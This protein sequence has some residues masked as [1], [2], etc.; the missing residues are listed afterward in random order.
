MNDN[1][2]MESVIG[3][4]ASEEELTKRKEN[5][6]RGVSEWLDVCVREDK[7]F[8][9]KLDEILQEIK[10]SGRMSDE[11]MWCIHYL[12]NSI[13][14]LGMD[15]KALREESPYPESYNPESKVVEPTADGLKL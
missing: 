12:K 14:W 9:R 8:R 3:S 1:E 13:M 10:K 11:R 4:A 5:I 2:P 6:K 15:L 7:L